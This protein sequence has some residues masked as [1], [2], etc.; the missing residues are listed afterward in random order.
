VDVAS[1]RFY[2]AALILA[3]T[4]GVVL[5]W[6]ARPAAEAHLPP[7]S[8]VRA[9]LEIAVGL[10][11]AA[12]TGWHAPLLLAVTLASIRVV[13]GFSYRAWGGIRTASLVWVRAVVALAVFVI[14]VLQG[15]SPSP[16]AR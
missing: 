15:S 12:W 16:F 10:A 4:A 8:T 3:R 9:G 13:L 2:V 7:L 14:A 1:Y 5:L 6:I 11:V